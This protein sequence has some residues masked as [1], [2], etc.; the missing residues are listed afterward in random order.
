MTCSTENSVSLG[1]LLCVHFPD[2]FA[3]LE[4][5][6][7]QKETETREEDDIS[8]V[9]SVPNDL[10]QSFIVAASALESLQREFEAIEIQNDAANLKPELPLE[11]PGKSEKLRNH[12]QEM[13]PTRKKHVLKLIRQRYKK[14]EA[15]QIRKENCRKERQNSKETVDAADALPGNGGAK[16]K[17]L[18]NSQHNRQWSRLKYFERLLDN[19]MLISQVK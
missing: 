12:W 1:T 6:P 18:L 11:I 9:E 13:K 3:P 4:N 17:K 7:E 2:F 8:F 5:T 10:P 14:L 15:I 19:N 16:Q